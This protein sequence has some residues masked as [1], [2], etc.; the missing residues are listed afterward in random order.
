[1]CVYVMLGLCMYM[2][3]VYIKFVPIYYNPFAR[4]SHRL[5]PRFHPIRMVD[6]FSVNMFVTFYTQTRGLIFYGP[7]QTDT[8]LLRLLQ[9][10]QL[11][12][13]IYMC[14]FRITCF[15]FQHEDICDLLMLEFHDICFELL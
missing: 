4:D 10:E 11:Y 14:V 5:Q 15:F 6:V 3:C 12:D 2:R 1:M 7:G 8:I 9:K 13:Y